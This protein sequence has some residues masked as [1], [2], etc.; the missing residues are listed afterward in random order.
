MNAAALRARLAAVS[1]RVWLVAIVVVSA[2]VRIALARRMVAPWIMVD[3]LVY[4][5]LAKSIAAHG[6]F[7][8]RGVPSSGYGVVYP[9]LIAPAWRLFGAVPDAYAAAKVINAVVMSLAAVPAYGI[10]R[11]VL[12]SRAS[13]VA[14]ALAVTVP[15]MLYTGTLMT[16]NGFYPVFLTACLAL[17]VM[18]ERP[19]LRTQ[20]VVLAVC[21]IAY[22][23]CAQAIAL[24]AAAATAPLLLAASERGAVRAALRPF[25]LIYGVLIGGGLLVLLAEVARGKSPLDLLGAYRAATTSTY[26]ASGILHYLLYHWG[27]LSLYVGVVP[28]AALAAVWLTPTTGTRAVRE[29]G[30]AHV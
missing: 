29:I 3:E 10:G 1:P 23:T 20:L 11:R 4:S 22:L 24:V 30:R 16:E 27:E 9:L 15:S 7:L 8:V 5:E 2:I 18:L 14:A 26:T 19:T 17:V 25:A 6:H 12:S 21:G 28:F 13:L